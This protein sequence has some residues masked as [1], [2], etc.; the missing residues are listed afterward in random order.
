MIKKLHFTK[1]AA[2][3][4]ALF[5]AVCSANAATLFE[6]FDSPSAASP[7]YNGAT[8]SYNS[9]SW[10]TNGITKPTT[11]TENDRINGLY[12]IRMRGLSTKNLLTMNFNKVDGAGT[13]SF[14]YG[15][16][17]NHNGGKFIVEKSTDNGSSW[18]S[19]SSEITVPAWVGTFHTYSIV[20]NES[21]AVRFRLVMTVT[22]DANTLVNIDDFMVT[23]YGTT[24]VVMPS[25]SV[26]TGVYETPQT[27][28]LSTSTPDAT[29]YYTTDGSEP[30]TASN[31]YV[32][33]LNITQTTQFR[34][35]A[36]ASNKVDAR[37]EVVLISFPEAVATLADFYT[38]MATT[39][40]NL[41]YFKYTGEAVVS[42]AYST[43]SN[44]VL[45]FQDNTAGMIINDQNKKLATTYNTGDKITGIIAQV[46]RLNDSPQLY[47]YA[48][49]TVVS[50]GNTITP[51]VIALSDVPS[52]TNQLVRINGL[53]FTEANGTKIFASNTSYAIT[54]ANTLSTTTVFRAPAMST[55][56]DYLTTVIP[57]TKSV[58]AVVAKNSTTVATHVIFARS[59][60]DFITSPTGI[61]QPT[62]L[63]LYVSNGKV[64]FETST[65]KEITVYSVSG[66]KIKSLLS[67]S[68]KNCIELSKGIY[69]IRIGEQVAKIVL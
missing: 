39:G 59:L 14:K 31:V 62:V 24:Q 37:E 29:I 50:T 54:D 10:F 5:I 25:S 60:T 65:S 3:I 47:P 44:K 20:V 23:D 11:P 58:I 27:V 21:A 13:L 4:V 51:E 22:S 56:L 45:F 6:N 36:T 38:K 30:T 43:T 28:T 12:S 26:S 8:I 69:L 49:F 7:N 48:D 16:Y 63:P 9:G 1:L 18:A 32:T 17:S 33:P 66:Q 64:Y 34:M 2:V 41:T 42:Y 55:T 19:I 57:A 15:S 61:Q 67:E 35:F 46:N 68:G 52:R 40:T 53:N